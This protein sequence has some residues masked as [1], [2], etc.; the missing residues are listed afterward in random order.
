MTREPRKTP[1][2]CLAPRQITGLEQLGW[3]FTMTGPNEWDWIKFGVNG[4]QEARGG[5][6]T[7][8]RD[9]RAVTSIFM[10]SVPHD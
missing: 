10:A 7:W 8:K 4:R 6:A 1:S 2:G 3:I 9:L 5:D